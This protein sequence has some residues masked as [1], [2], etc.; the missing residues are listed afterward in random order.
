MFKREGAML[1]KRLITIIL[2]FTTF[3][4]GCWDQTIYERTGF[5]LQVGIE[6]SNNNLLI[7]YTD[8]VV[9][10][11]SKEKVEVIYGSKENLL[12]EFREDA[13]K[14]SSKMLEAGK[15]Q[16]VLISDSIAAKGINNLLEIFERDPTTSI[17]AYVV[18]V[19]GSPRNLMEKAQSFGDKPRP[20]FYIHQ[21]IEDNVEQSY[22]PDTQIHRFT[23]TFFSPGIDPIT[24]IIKLQYD[25]GKGIEVTGSALFSEDKM[26]GKIDTNQTLLLLSMMGKAKKSVYV[27]KHFENPGYNNGK[28]GCAIG[29]RKVKRKVNVYLENN[30]PIADIALNFDGSLNEMHWNSIP[31]LEAQKNIEKTLETEIKKSCEQ[32]LTYTQKVHSDPLGIG[33]IIRAK[34]NS[35]FENVN[36]KNVYPSVK[37]NVNVKLN[38]SGHGVIN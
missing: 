30:I 13:R 20:A 26:V 3:L 4:E 2:I 36:W 18:V 38:I 23:T 24:P 6:P 5:I 11:K 29:I 12:R 31:D 14:I 15:V 33:D 21:L 9:E 37:F 22:V 1:K 16:Q 32:V 35:Y 10:P 19:E 25:K 17:I 34:Y 28:R 7:T 27:S 8:P